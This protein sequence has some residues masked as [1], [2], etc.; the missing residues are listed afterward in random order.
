MSNY[1]PESNYNFPFLKV[2]IKLTITCK[3]FLDLCW[4]KG[5]NSRNL[6]VANE[7]V[8]DSKPYITSN[9]GKIKQDIEKY[10]KFI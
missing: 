9:A 2:Q 1:V 7:L 10:S 6:L 5:E 3:C 8:K 4:K